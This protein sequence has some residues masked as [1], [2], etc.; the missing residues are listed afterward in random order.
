MI[1]LSQKLVSS[2][3][4]T[5]LLSAGESPLMLANLTADTHHFDQD[6]TLGLWKAV[7]GIPIQVHYQL[8]YS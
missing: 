3:I 8:V 4:L 6:H 1:C 2:V 5:T 7:A